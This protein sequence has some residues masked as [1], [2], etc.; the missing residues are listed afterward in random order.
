MIVGVHTQYINAIQ[1]NPPHRDQ[2]S[3]DEDILAPVVPHV[4]N[5]YR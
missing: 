3:S 1:A 5:P 4:P 2:D